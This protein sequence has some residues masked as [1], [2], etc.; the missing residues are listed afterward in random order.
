MAILGGSVACAAGPAPGTEAVPADSMGADVKTATPPPATAPLSTGTPPSSTAPPPTTEP[1]ALVLEPDGTIVPRG[2]RTRPLWLE[3]RCAGAP[4]PA[5]PSPHDVPPPSSASA[6]AQLRRLV[7]SFERYEP[8]Y[9]FWDS[10][11]QEVSTE[12]MCCSDLDPSTLVPLSAA[13]TAVE[14][15]YVETFCMDEP[16]CTLPVAC[17]RLHREDSLLGYRFSYPAPAF[18]DIPTVHLFVFV[19]GRVAGAVEEPGAGGLGETSE[20]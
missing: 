16:D 9:E 6:F 1:P 14:P 13:I 11:G 20:R 15:Q 4:T 5:P 7:R 17:N 2:S 18:D 19:D 10:D 12:R 3:P 8:K